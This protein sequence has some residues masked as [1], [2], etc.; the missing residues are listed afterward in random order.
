MK[1]SLYGIL[2]LLML[3]SIVLSAC[4]G[5]SAGNGESGAG[6]GAEAS[7]NKASGA[8]AA[9]DTK[10]VVELTWMTRPPSNDEQARIRK[11]TIIDPF[12]RKYPNIK[13]KLIENQDPDLLTRQQ[14]AAG[15]GPD[16][17]VV[18][19]PTTLMQFASAGYLLPLDSYTE[20]YGWKN[21]FYDWAFQ[22]GFYEGKLYGLP[23]SYESLVVWY[24][25][26]MFEQNGW[27]TPTGFDEFMALNEQ[28]KQAG[29]M[30]FAFGTTEFRASNE[31]WLSLVY[32]SYL[33][34]DEFKKVLKNET[35]WTSDLVKQA[36]QTWVDIWQ[37]G[38][39]NDK[40]SHS[41]SLEDAWFLFNNQKAAMKME[42][43]WALD[44]LI[45]SPP[46]FETD[47]FVMPAWRSGVEP[48]L[49]MALGEAVGINA[50]TKY[51]D[52]TAAFLDFFYGAER[53]KSQ[54]ELG[55]FM[56]INGID[57]AQAQTKSPLVEKV[58]TELNSAFEKGNPGYAS[59]TYWPPRAQQYLWDNIDSVFL[60]QM[61]VDDYLA[62]AQKKADEDEAEGM[63]FKF[64]D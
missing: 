37:K 40:Q 64:N 26:D 57:I 14:L 38:Y 1:R 16:I 51:P 62:E 29:I 27:K 56:P 53:A 52:E 35:P 9:A 20:K 46:P 3:V 54:L 11:E 44:R 4:S 10:E 22:T 18:D 32:N 21:K 33:G 49:P 60:G 61:T 59:W 23:G 24:N 47:F 48:T 55:T 45:T 42:G 43:T 7:G 8:N 6:N 17:I 5:G 31:W 19:G 63:L 58:Y 12:E 13:L 36:T 2:L 25:K 28:I 30:P 50:K 39:I 41:I 15:A 34:A